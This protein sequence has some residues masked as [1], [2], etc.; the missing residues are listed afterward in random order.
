VRGKRGEREA[1]LRGKRGE[2]DTIS[3][4]PLLQA[5][6]SAVHLERA[7]G[8]EGERKTARER[9]GRRE[10]EKERREGG[11]GRE[12]KKESE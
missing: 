7:R 11:G 8:R 6:C 1:G 4:L 5:Q 9:E 2:G 12:G 3:I 10:R